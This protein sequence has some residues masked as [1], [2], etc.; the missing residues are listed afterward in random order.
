MDFSIVIPA[1]NEEGNIQPLYQKIKETLQ[2]MQSSFEVIFVDDGSSD[3]TA[4]RVAMLRKKDKRVRLVQFARNFGK[5]SALSAGMREAKGNIVVTMDADLQDDPEEIPR[6]HEKLQQGFD[7]VVGWKYKRKD[8]FF[9]KKLPSK[10]FNGLIRWLHKIKI[11]DSDCNFRMMRKEVAKEILFYGGLFRY[12]PS[13]AHWRGY[14]VTEIPV[15]HHKRFSGKSKWGVSRLFKGSLD[16]ITVTFL[17]RYKNSP[18]YFFG[19]SGGI[20]LLAGIIAGIRL[21]Y[22]KYALGKLIGGRPLLL[23]AI[24]LTVLG[25][26]FIFFGLLGEMIAR[27]SQ[28]EEVNYRIKK[29]L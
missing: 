6:M 23:L 28:K 15:V 24:L 7:L 14:R 12:I 16:L 9:A 26:Q 8:A 20:L 27:T 17:L 29:R 13:L 25:A 5:A 4:A 18:L 11:H 22:E 19:T 2:S 3:N 10:I 1:F 21:L